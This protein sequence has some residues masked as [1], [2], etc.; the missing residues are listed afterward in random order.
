MGVPGARVTA[1]AEL[2]PALET[3]FRA[4]RPFLIDVAV[5]GR[6]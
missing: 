4:P 1:P 2:R 3:A 6:A 5:E